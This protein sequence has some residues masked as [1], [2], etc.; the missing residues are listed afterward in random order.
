V[1]RNA[2]YTLRK[3]GHGSAFPA[4][5]A[6]LDH[7]DSRVRLEAVRAAIQVGGAAAR[8]PVLRRVHDPNTSVQR[9]AISAVGTPG[10][11][12]AVPELRK[13]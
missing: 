10:N 12:D 2:L 4:I 13:V 1:V 7:P 8:A 6:A 3:I 5:V 11:D 9:A